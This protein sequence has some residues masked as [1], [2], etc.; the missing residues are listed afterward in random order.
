M[1]GRKG[2]RELQPLL[3]L[4]DIRSREVN[5]VDHFDIEMDEKPSSLPFQ[6]RSSFHS[7]LD[8]VPADHPVG[9]LDQRA[10]CWSSSNL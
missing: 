7:T 6:T 1:K 10:R 2:I 4:Q 5:K 8:G 9:K 3:R